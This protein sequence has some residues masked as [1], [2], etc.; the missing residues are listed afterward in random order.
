MNPRRLIITLVLSFIAS[1]HAEDFSFSVPFDVMNLPPEIRFLRVTCTV[2]E[3]GSPIGSGQYRVGVSGGTARGEAVVAFNAHRGQDA[4]RATRW[5]C[6]LS[7][8]VDEAGE[9]S[10][11]FTEPGDSFPTVSRNITAQGDIRR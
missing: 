2:W 11:A 3:H 7:F 5:T 1:A 4:Q 8:D 6:G 10:Y 9:K